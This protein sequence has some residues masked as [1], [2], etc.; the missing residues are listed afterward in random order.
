MLAQVLGWIATFLFSVALIPQIVKTAK[1]RVVT[2][3]SGWEFIINLVANVVALCYAL[4]IS[5]GPLVF[6]YITA[7]LLTALYLILYFVFKKDSDSL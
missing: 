1:T 5:Q 2:G 3:V 6:K 7:L 4:L